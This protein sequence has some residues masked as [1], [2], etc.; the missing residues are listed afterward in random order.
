M[1]MIS[2]YR[3]LTY[4]VTGMEQRMVN[5]AAENFIVLVFGMIVVQM[6]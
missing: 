1:I 6:F 3:V 5:A 4:T 2:Y